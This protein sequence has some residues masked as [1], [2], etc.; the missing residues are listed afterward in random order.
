MLTCKHGLVNAAY[1]VKNLIRSP[2]RLIMNMSIYINEGI[3]YKK[4]PT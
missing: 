3:Y 4:A 2:L 1:Y